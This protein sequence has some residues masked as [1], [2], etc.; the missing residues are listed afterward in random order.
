LK[1]YSGFCPVLL[2]QTHGGEFGNFISFHV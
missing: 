1:P 2:R